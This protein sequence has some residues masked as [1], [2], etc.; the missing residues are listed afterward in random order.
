MQNL[1]I[2]FSG[3][4]ITKIKNLNLRVDRIGSVLFVLFALYE[5]RYDLLDEFDD[6]NRQ[7]FAL[8]LYKDL[9]MRG[10]LE[11]NTQAENPHFILSNKGIEFVESIKKEFTNAPTAVDIAV[12]GADAVVREPILSGSVN[13][14]EEWLDLFPRG[15]RSGGKLL[16]ADAQSCLKKMEIFI[17]T[18]PA[19]TKEVIM[20]ATRRYLEDRAAVNYEYTRCAVYFIYRM[21]RQGG[22]TISDLASWCDQVAHEKNSPEPKDNNMDIMV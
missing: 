2:Q 22:E 15:V 3:N 7:K 10:L 21:E 6:S 17:K 19:Y 4:I 14:I 18:Y 9:E 12:F 5:K 13:W 8:L 1:E 16:R 11:Q 20:E